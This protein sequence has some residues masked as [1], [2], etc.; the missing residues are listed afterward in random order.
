MQPDTTYYVRAYAVNSVGVAYSNVI[1]FTTPT[2]AVPPPITL[3]SVAAESSY[4]AKFTTNVAD[5]GGSP[6]TSRGCNFYTN[7]GFT[8]TPI[9]YDQSQ[10]TGVITDTVEGLQPNTAYWAR[11]WVTNAIGT[12][13][14]NVINFATPLT[15]IVPSITLT[16]IT[17]TTSSSANYLADVTSG[18]DSTILQRGCEFYTSPSLNG[19]FLSSYHSLNEEGVF[20]GT[21]IDLQPNTTYYARAMVRNTDWI[22]Y[23]NSISFT[24]GA[25]T[26]TPTITLES[27]SPLRMRGVDIFNN[28]GLTGDYTSIVQT[29][30]IGAMVIASGNMEPDTNYWA[31]AWALNSLT[32]GVQIATTVGS[33][34]GSTV[35]GRGCDLFTTPDCSGT[36]IGFTQ[37]SVVGPLSNPFQQQLQSN[38]TYYARA[39]AQNANGIGYSNIV[40]FY[41]GD[42]LQEVVISLDVTV[43]SLTSVIFT[44]VIEYGSGYSDGSKS[45]SPVVSFTT[46]SSVPLVSA[47]MITNIFYDRFDYSGTVNSDG[48]S[49]IIQRGIVWNLT[50]NPTLESYIG[51]TT[52]AGDIGSFSGTAPSL[53][54][55]QTVRILAYAKNAA[56]NVGYSN[57]VNF[58][59]LRSRIISITEITS[60]S[61]V[62]NCIVEGPAQDT[63]SSRGV[64]FAAHPDPQSSDMLHLSGNG[65]GEFSV[66]VQSNPG[67]VITPNTTYFIKV[68]TLINGGIFFPESENELTFT[69][70]P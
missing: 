38:T 24:T 69:T 12:T 62:A 52:D 68:H 21:V 43:Q 59:S 29:L 19:D 60:T 33:D 50:G 20:S 2:V 67:H 35:T 41:T 1:S 27:V 25:P 3:S 48:G 18:G 42:L 5:S 8:G 9:T 13:L 39:W 44:A 22:S 56:G 14:S 66:L 36:P 30:G 64:I 63:I 45:Y 34:G 28:S 40:S 32:A 51:I 49:S 26:V 53:V 58:Y 11:A 23:S 10:N 57:E 4:T 47:G 65:K 15:G 37:Q 17:G 16:S 54:T 6:I 70:L 61:F 55:S 46:T 31:R 7:S